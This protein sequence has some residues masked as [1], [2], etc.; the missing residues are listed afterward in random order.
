M[1]DVRE[2]D[3]VEL[4]A[5]VSAEAWIGAGGR[6]VDFDGQPVEGPLPD[7]P[8]GTRGAIVSEPIPGETFGLVELIDDEGETLDV[9]DVPWGA[10]RV[11]WRAPRDA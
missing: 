1:E 8:A 10:A 5:P 4:T 9:L 3:V 6:P 2:H 7:W 11:V